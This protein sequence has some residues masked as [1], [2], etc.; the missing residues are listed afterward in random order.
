MKT[1][2]KRLKRITMWD[3]TTL[4]AAWRYY[5][6]RRTIASAMF[7]SEIVE[8]FF[9]GKYSPDD[10]MKIARQFS[11]VDHGIRGAADWDGFDDCDK[12]PWQTF[13]Y[14]CKAY[15][16]NTFVEIK[17]VDNG[18]HKCFR[19]ESRNRWIPVEIY[20][21]SPHRNMWLADEAIVDEEVNLNDV[22]AVCSDCANA[23][24]CKPKPKTVGVWIDTCGICKERK[25]C[26]DLWHDWIVPKK[27]ETK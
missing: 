11:E 1:K 10:E 4:V 21:R 19:D 5:E 16:R 15:A 13:Y 17:T 18:L 12:V 26:T 3:W 27:G 22:S 24:G 2:T 23:A 14:F 25:P 20:L 8:R 9:T 6:G 7:P